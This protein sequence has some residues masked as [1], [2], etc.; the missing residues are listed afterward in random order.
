MKEHSY[1][2]ANSVF[3]TESGHSLWIGDIQAAE[4]VAWIK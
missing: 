4:N 2:H 1:N 3:D